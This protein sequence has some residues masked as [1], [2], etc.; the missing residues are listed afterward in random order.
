[1]LEFLLW[2]ILLVP[3]LIFP[4]LS[5]TRS[6]REASTLAITLAI[7]P[8]SMT[9]FLLPNG[10]FD[11]TSKFIIGI[12]IAS[13][14]IA[15]RENVVWRASRQGQYTY[16]ET[17]LGISLQTLVGRFLIRFLQ[18]I[19]FVLWFHALV[20]THIGWW[21]I[22]FITAAF[23]LAWTEHIFGWKPRDSSSVDY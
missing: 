4:L 21:F 20:Q 14:G 2:L 9:P 18:W 22:T 8:F 15:F 11:I 13:I 17:L 7:I 1:M 3:I 19:P 5:A 23:L 10:Y 12:A 6:T 16:V